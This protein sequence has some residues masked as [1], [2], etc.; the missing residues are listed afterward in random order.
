VF[1]LHILANERT[2]NYSLRFL[3]DTITYFTTFLSAQR[4]DC[5]LFVISPR[6]SPAAVAHLLD[7]VKV[8]HLLVGREPSMQILVKEA[9]ELLTS[10]Y[11]EPKVPELSPMP[12]FQELYDAS[13]PVPSPESLPLT[14]TKT[15]DLSIYFHS[16]GST[17]FPK[18]T[19][20]SNKHFL[21]FGIN[22]FFG[23]H[24]FCGKTLALHIMP[25][26]HG[27]G[28][29][30]TALAAMTGLQFSVFEP[31]FPAVVPTAESALEAAMKTDCDIMLSPPTF[32]ETWSRN[33]D[34]K[35]WLASKTGVVGFIYQILSS[36][37]LTNYTALWRRTPRQGCW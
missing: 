16:S 7:K 24:D 27:M 35:K 37:K 20:V 12:T 14:N 25:I 32:I 34:A 11:E 23:G 18:P 30:Q 5:I 10:K 15:D 28:A 21:E 3:A 2:Y 26:Y 4:A 22:A 36:S 29:V 1:L 13:V 31:R 9:L 19:F 33:E 8:D 17:N 6:N